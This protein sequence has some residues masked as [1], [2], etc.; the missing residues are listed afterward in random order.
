MHPML[1]Q[2]SSR[3][4]CIPAGSGCSEDTWKMWDLLRG[5]RGQPAN[6][7][8]NW[9]ETE[10]VAFLFGSLVFPGDYPVISGLIR[11]RSVRLGF[12]PS[13]SIV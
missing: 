7:F 10:E 12:L 4:T 1:H 5:D 9:T 8:E 6:T 2:D 11:T 3:Y 13:F